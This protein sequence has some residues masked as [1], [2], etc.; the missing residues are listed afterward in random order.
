MNAESKN[1][2]CKCSYMSLKERSDFNYLQCIV[3]SC[4][5]NE[6]WE[7]WIYCALKVSIPCCCWYGSFPAFRTP[8]A[9]LEVSTQHCEKTLCGRYYTVPTVSGGS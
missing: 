5:N 7:F 9:L 3:E 2:R 1:Q 6:E 8:G 4:S